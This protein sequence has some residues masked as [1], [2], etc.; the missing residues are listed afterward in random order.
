MRQHGVMVGDERFPSRSFVLYWRAAAVSAFGTYI[1]LLALQTLVILTLHGSATQ[2]GW[3]S[4][5]RWLP[6]LVVGV[7]VGALVDRHPRRPVMVA[8]DLVQAFLLAAIPLLWWRHLLSF[9]TLLGIVMAYGTAS[10]ING[11]AAMS[12][13]PRLVSRQHLQRAHARGDGADAVAM[14]A[15]P[16]LGGLLVSTLGAPVAVLVDAAT[17]LCSAVTLS[18]IRVVEPRPREGGTAT[19][20]LLTEI[21]D[22]VRWA[23]RGSGLRTLAL[24][25]HVWFLGNAVVGVVLAPYALTVLGLTPFQLGI[26]GALG[27]IGALLGASV[28]TWV[29][30]RLG[31]GRTIIACDVV[32]AGGALVMVAAG[33]PF[34]GWASVAVLG[35]G[36]GLYGLAMGMSNSHEMSFR[37][38][39]TPDE[40]QARTNTTLRSLNR[41]V[42]VVAAPLAGVLADAW[43]IRPTLLVA[44]ATFALAAAGLALSPF[45]TVRAPV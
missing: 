21:C 16:A 28:T 6:Y 5:A 25:T 40:L 8:T 15:G 43:G 4:S 13:L 35:A 30:L 24:S 1:T 26:I 10:V 41:A 11:A 42:M 19:R 29:G 45:R 33:G 36:Q 9:P 39:V 14:S 31:T 2:V 20:D 27:G 12:F 22:G 7:V 32:S 34:H 18:R 23:Y 38:L 3:L 37:Q 17:Y 44:T